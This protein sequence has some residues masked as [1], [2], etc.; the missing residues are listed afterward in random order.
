MWSVN[1]LNPL[2]RKAGKAPGGLF[3]WSAFSPKGEKMEMKLKERG[4][5]G[6]V[7]L[8]AM[9]LALW[10]IASLGAAAQAAQQETPGSQEAV[11]ANEV[12]VTATKTPHA[13]ADVPVDTVVITKEEIKNMPATNMVDVLRMIPG[14]N[15]STSDDV[16]GTYSWL[17]TMRGLSVNDGYALILIDG[18]R[19]LG[20]GQSGGMGEYGIG[21]NQVPLEMVD[22]IEVVRG[23]G[24][25]LYGSD[26]MAGVINIITKKI[27]KKF[28]GSA[29]ASYGWYRIKDQESNGKTTKPEDDGDWRNPARA[30]VSVGDKVRESSGYY[31]N[32]SYEQAEDTGAEPILSTR[33][34]FMGKWST[35]VSDKLSFHLRG[36]TS[37]YEKQD[38]RR[39]YTYRASLGAEY[40]PAAGHR[41]S[42]K[43]YYYIWDFEH[44]WPPN[45][46]HGHKQGDV[47]YTNGQMQYDWTKGNNLLT[48]GGEFQQQGIDY[49]IDNADGTHIPVN[50][51][52]DTASIFIQDEIV[53]F[54]KLTLVG[55]VRLDDHSTFG[56]SVNPKLSAMYRL[57][58]DTTLRGSVGRAY[59]SPT[60]RQLYY[61]KAYEHGDWY[62]ASNP[63]LKPEIAI[64]Y[65]L[66][67]EQWTFN[68]ALW[69][70][71]GLFR[72]DV[73]DMV[74]VE[75]TGETINGKP[76]RSY[77]N[78]DQALVQGVEAS[79]RWLPVEGFSLTAGLTWLQSEDKS[80]GNWLTYVPHYNLVINP[81]Y[82]Y[83]PWGLGGSLVFMAIGKSYKDEDNLQEIEAYTTWDL[84]V[85]KRLSQGARL[86]FDA[87]NLTDSDKGDPS[88]WRSGR[89]FLVSLD[90]QF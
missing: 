32:Y 47:S 87:K 80:T 27:P 40:K 24:S 50:K 58:N 14:I 70:N 86:S 12:V 13:L 85:F 26:A 88:M 31:L 38:N 63:D 41:L 79:A 20:A 51:E 53:F 56:T 29:G 16:F 73:D 33:H 61:G 11:Q 10:A 35:K 19:V 72:T 21:I 8:T 84:K 71:L 82:E 2:T 5:L 17:A 83:L 62:D 64:G 49:S 69:L 57:T 30:Y 7:L 78:V 76:V 42:F 90:V 45:N 77:K 18:E 52:V 65:N 54:D 4:F 22:R 34:Y 67:L 28:S 44:G 48:L 37:D 81:C 25:A 15:T 39:E 75:A 59:K 6:R 55:G 66:S 60:I 89:M 1:D 68:R 3:L 23:T 46:T 9:V 43:T 74:V 36:E